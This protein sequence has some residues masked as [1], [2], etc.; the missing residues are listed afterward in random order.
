MAW[1]GIAGNHRGLT[2]VLVNYAYEKW[3]LGS[4]YDVR[5]VRSAD[6]ISDP[7]QQTRLQLSPTNRRVTLTRV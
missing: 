6:N 7:S 4:G 1:Y 3:T 2:N 5:Y